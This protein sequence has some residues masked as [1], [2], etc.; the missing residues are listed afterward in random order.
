[1][2]DMATDGGGQAEGKSNELPGLM[3][4]GLLFVAW[5]GTNIWFNM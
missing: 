3:A 2:R 4:L 1:M 5:Y